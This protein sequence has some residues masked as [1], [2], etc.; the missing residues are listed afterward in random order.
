MLKIKDITNIEKF[1]EYGFYFDNGFWFR[2]DNLIITKTGYIKGVG[3]GLT[4]EEYDNPI[5]ANDLIEAGLVV[6]ED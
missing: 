3:I 5:Q 1:R 6:K 4:D 2:S